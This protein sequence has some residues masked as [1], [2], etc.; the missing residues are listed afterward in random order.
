MQRECPWCIDIIRTQFGGEAQ[1]SLRMWSEKMPH[2][3]VSPVSS[4]KKGGVRFHQAARI[5]CGFS[6]DRSLTGG[7]SVCRIF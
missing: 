5:F 4:L 1:E 6:Q 2:T 7:S 3:E